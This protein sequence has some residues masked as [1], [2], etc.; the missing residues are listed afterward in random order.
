MKSKL[1]ATFYGNFDELIAFQELNRISSY[2]L[3]YESHIFRFENAKKALRAINKLEAIKIIREI[4]GI[5]LTEAKKYVE[6]DIFV[7]AAGC[8]AD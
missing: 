2:N 4:S 6:S 5:G 1:N 8:Q 3:I 7:D